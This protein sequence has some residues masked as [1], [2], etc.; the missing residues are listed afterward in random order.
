MSI[1]RK[2]V[3][4][5]RRLLVRKKNVVAPAATKPRSSTGKRKGSGRRGPAAVPVELS[6]AEQRKLAAVIRRER[7]PQALAMRVRVVL[8]LAGEPTSCVAAVAEQWA[9]GDR[10]YVRKWR[11]R[12]HKDGIEGLKTRLRP[13]RPARIGAVSRCQVMAMACGKPADF[14]VPHRTGWTLKS[15]SEAY[16]AKQQAVPEL[17]PMSRT[18]ILRI[19]D[20]ADI[21]PHRI[22][23][24]LHSPDP[25]FREKVTEICELYLRPPP[26]THVLCVDEKTGM[27]ALGRKHPS[28]TPA[29]G[30]DP[31]MD[32]EYVRNGTRKLIACWDTRTGEVYGEVRANRKAVDLVEFMEAVARK[33]PEG[34]VHIIW[35][36]LNIHY[37]GRAARWTEFNQR[38]G[39]RFHFHYTP[40]H[41]SW[42]NQIEL[43]FGIFHRRVLRHGV[44]NSLDELDK[45]VLG[46]IG[47]WNAHERKPFK[48]K[49]T[50][51][52]MQTGLKDAA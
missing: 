20:K 34:D 24:W 18:S 32:F 31:R 17:D 29:P 2:V 25:L 43:W 39:G 13:G 46:F 6:R 36:N 42:V 16:T 8:A 21:R 51:Y 45:A 1:V 30:R 23:M 27:Q 48:W 40:I 35:D 44:F 9:N 47:H 7:T 22:K 38:H 37:D 41:A 5:A 33:Y 50:G 19:L 12:Y 52:P 49:F 15:L 28:R 14:D 11:D 26:G 3:S 4:A 10:K